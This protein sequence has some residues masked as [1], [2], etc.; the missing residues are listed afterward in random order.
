MKFDALSAPGKSDATTRSAVQAFAINLDRS[1]ER[2]T[3]M[4]AR[5]GRLAIPWQRVCA[6][7]GHQLALSSLENVDAD[8]YGRRHG[9]YLNPAEVGCYLPHLGALE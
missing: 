4:S 7:D 6:I 3:N 2:M 8:L 5:L 9:K 1:P